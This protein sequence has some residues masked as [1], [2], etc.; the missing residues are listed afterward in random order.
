MT[1][2][3]TGLSVEATTSFADSSTYGTRL[4]KGTLIGLLNSLK[5]GV[6]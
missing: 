1:M 4:R 2:G 6:N 5:Y 3:T